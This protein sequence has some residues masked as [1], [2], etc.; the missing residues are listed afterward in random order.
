MG[1]VW[2]VPDLTVPM[3]VLAFIGIVLLLAG[4]R[5]AGHGRMLMG[6]GGALL[7]AVIIVLAVLAFL[8]PSFAV[9]MGDAYGLERF[10]CERGCPGVGLP[11]DRTPASWMEDGRLIHG[12]IIVDDDGT[13]LLAG[14]DGRLLSP[15][16]KE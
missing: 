5:D 10:D 1:G 8:V 4:L 9:R 12:T 15:K 14:P 6:V 16:D 11:A 3:L 13:A 2:A 7:A